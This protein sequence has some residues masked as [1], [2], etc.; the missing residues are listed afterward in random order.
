MGELAKKEQF[1]IQKLPHGL[2]ME[3]KRADGDLSVLSEAIEFDYPEHQL[4]R[5]N[6]RSLIAY[7]AKEHALDVTADAPRDTEATAHLIN[8]SMFREVQRL[9]REVRALSKIA[10]QPADKKFE[11]KSSG[12]IITPTQAQGRLILAMSQLGQYGKMINEKKKAE[13][14]GEG[15]GVSVNVNF[16]M[17]QMM[18]DSLKRVKEVCIDM[19]PD[20]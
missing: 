18:T 16:E 19:D 3:A 1:D 6:L 4:T 7:V 11:L 17:Q 9:N 5:A 12:E 13:S 2:I 14:T 8:E 20:D 10:E 15:P